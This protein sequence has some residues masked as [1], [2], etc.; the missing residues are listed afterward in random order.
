MPPDRELADQIQ[1]VLRH[2]PKGM[3]ITEL[4]RA[5]DTNREAVA[6]QLDILE[7]SGKVELR[8][9]GNAKVY[10]AAQRVPLASF[11]CFTK[12]LIIVLDNRQRIIQVNDQCAKFLNLP[13]EE[14]VGK[15]IQEAK[16]PVVSSPEA[17]SLIREVEHE[18]IITDI[19][20]Q[21][22]D[23]E[24]FFH[25][26]VIPTTFENGE[27]GCT[28]V[29]ED[30]TERKQYVRSMEFLGRT[31]WELVDLPLSADIYE[32]IAGRIIELIPT[33]MVYVQSY[34]EVRHQFSI[35]AIAG[36]EFHE[37]LV[38]LLGKD[39]IGMVLPTDSIFEAPFNETLPSFFTLREFVFR[40]DSGEETTSFYEICFQQIP[41]E[42]CDAILERFG[43]DRFYCTGLI[44]EN[45]L[46]GLVG[47]FMPQG[48]RLDKNQPL[49]SFIRQASIAIAMRMTTERLSRSEHRFREVMDLSPGP[50]SIIE[51]DGRYT[52]VNP[53]FT[54]LFGYTLADIPSGRTWFE[55][56][57]PD[58]DYRQEAIDAWKYDLAHSAI[59]QI[60]PRTFRVHCR[61]GDLKT[62][63]FQPVTLQDGHQYITYKETTGK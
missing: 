37:G 8:Y 50:M 21:G 54:R 49:E 1:K 18:Q 33:S 48:E 63:Q 16:V 32:Y 24:H 44:W 51:S 55:K 15:T 11:L 43:I 25:L 19:R 31:A 36:R 13:K 56:A 60:R 62:I 57:F 61:N 29:L 58:P 2:K 9:I 38:Q 46:F 3:T 6:R 10:Y 52:H 30:I 34:D 53:E 28:L 4:A 35:R 41:P 26:Q 39:P 47:I 20:Y 45:Q 7:V 27:K 12:N 42:I 22:A 40:S 5:L 59:G 14:I 17:L 23:Q